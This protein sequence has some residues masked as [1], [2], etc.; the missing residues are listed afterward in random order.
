MIEMIPPISEVVLG[1]TWVRLSEYF[2][3]DA[4]KKREILEILKKEATEKAISSDVEKRTVSAE[5]W[6]D[7]EAYLA[8]ATDPN[9]VKIFVRKA[10]RAM[11]L[12]S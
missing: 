11:E 10:Q 6:F 8:R 2:D 4:T 1:T 5:D 9:D 3:L 12:M 7:E